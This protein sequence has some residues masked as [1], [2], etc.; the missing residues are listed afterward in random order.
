VGDRVDVASPNDEQFDPLGDLR[1]L[2]A[3]EVVER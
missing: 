1:R 2:L 3:D